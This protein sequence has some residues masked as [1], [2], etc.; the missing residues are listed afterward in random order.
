MKH[1][2]ERIERLQMALIG[3]GIQLEA[4]EKRMAEVRDRISRVG[5]PGRPKRFGETRDRRTHKETHKKHVMSAEGR[6]RI[7]DALKLR[8]RK[9]HKAKAADA[10]R[11]RVGD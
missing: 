1:A 11:V 3:F 6:K 9:Y 2:D 10:K 4:V 8:W 5:K 7:S